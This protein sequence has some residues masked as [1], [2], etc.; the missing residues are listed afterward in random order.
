VTEHHDTNT[1]THQ[2][3]NLI[4]ENGLQGLPGAIAVLIDQAMLIERSNHI[5][6][7]PYERSDGRDGHANGFKPKTLQTRVGKVQLSVPQVRRSSEPFYPSALERGQRSEVALK[8]AI[9]EMYLQG[10]STRRV[11]KVMGELCGFEVTST[12]VSRATASLDEMFE[13]WRTRPIS[14]EIAHLIVDATYEKV[15]VAGEVRSCALLVA[16]GIRKLDGK[17]TVLGCSVSLS[18]AEVHWREFFSSLKGRGLGLPRMIT[19]DAHEGLKAAL[20]ASFPG[21]PW[22]RC[23]FH[24]QRNAQAYVPKAGMKT[25]VAGA[26]RRIFDAGDRREADNRLEEALGTYRES[27]PKL[28]DWI[29]ENIAEGLA[30]LALPEPLRKRLRTSNACETLNKQIGRRTRVCGLFPNESS[31]LRLATAIVMEQSDDWET[32]KAYL[33]KTLL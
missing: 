22:Q 12:E 7:G 8:L 1:T 27:A 32:G 19:S 16:I 4:L 17:R 3:I 21:V 2:A 30:V 14:D 33:D 20:A 29:E 13:A 25:A 18:E 6:A 10:V 26:I 11:T 31:L 9:A 24:L 15:R 5:G 23:Q 28:A